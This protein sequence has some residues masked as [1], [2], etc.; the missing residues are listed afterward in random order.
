MHKTQP[1]LRSSNL[2]SSAKNERLA[3]VHTPDRSGKSIIG[4]STKQACPELSVKLE[5]NT[6]ALFHV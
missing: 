2:L 5:V 4:M 1:A 3:K 6:L